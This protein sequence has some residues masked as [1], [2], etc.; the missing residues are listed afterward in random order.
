MNQ[1]DGG[2]HPAVQEAEKGVDS[3]ELGTG[4]EEGSD[5]SIPWNVTSYDQNRLAY[6]LSMFFSSLCTYSLLMSSSFITF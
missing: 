5:G 6:K 2:T 4:Y 3:N 1:V